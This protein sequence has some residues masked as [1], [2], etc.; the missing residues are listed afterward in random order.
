MKNRLELAILPQP[1]ATT[2]GPTCLQAV[3]RYYGETLS[4]K[5]V[6]DDIRELDEGGTF[7][8]ILGTHALSR[9]YDVELYTFNLQVFEGAASWAWRSTRIASIWKPGARFG[10]KT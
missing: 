3:Y 5:D 6:I 1:S 8:C 9:G 4:L 7:A 2:C 10:L